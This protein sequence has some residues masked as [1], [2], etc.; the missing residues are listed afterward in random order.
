MATNSNKFRIGFV[1]AG[2]GS[3]RMG[4]NKALLPL[5][6]ERLVD[7]IVARLARQ[8]DQV[9][10]ASPTDF[11]TGL[12]FAPDDPTGVKGPAAGLFAAANWL[13]GNRPDAAHFYTAPVDAPFFPE[14][15]ILR[16]EAARGSAIAVA[17]GA[18][19]PTFAKWRREDLA[20]AR[21]ELAGQN[22]FSLKML[23]RFCAAAHVEWS[24]ATAF[25]NINTPEDLAQAEQ[26]LARAH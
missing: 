23:A 24:D 6:G 5:G 11:D 10:L 15:L 9:V 12:E 26:V 20:R 7:R 4:T 13:E 25:M 16:L 2:G 1:L 14:D 22:S 18:Q 19:Q 8:V 21:S 17:A 3:T